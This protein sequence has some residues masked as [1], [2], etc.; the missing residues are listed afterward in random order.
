MTEETRDEP[1]AEDF[2]GDGLQNAP[3]HDGGGPAP[4]DDTNERADDKVEVLQ[5]DGDPA[6]SAREDDP[7]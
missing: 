5:P 4:T 7:R 1:A 2:A 6:P 3:V